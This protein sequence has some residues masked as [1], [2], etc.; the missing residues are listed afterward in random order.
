MGDHGK[1]QPVWKKALETLSK[2]CAWWIMKHRSLKR[3][4]WSVEKRTSK[5]NVLAMRWRANESWF[6]VT[7]QQCVSENHHAFSLSCAKGHLEVLRLPSESVFGCGFNYNNRQVFS[8]DFFTSTKFSPLLK[9]KHWTNI[10]MNKNINKNCQTKGDVKLVSWQWQLHS[11]IAI[12]GHSRF[13]WEMDFSFF[14]ELKEFLLVDYLWIYN[15]KNEVHNF[16]STCLFWIS[17]N[18]C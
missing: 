12:I 8:L 13:D 5:D 18:L 6:G 2:I 15:T 14:L 1:V 16:G 10:F 11:Y 4:A 7:L 3:T 17:P 9:K